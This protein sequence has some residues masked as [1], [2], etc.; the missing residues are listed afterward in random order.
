MS[1]LFFFPRVVGIQMST[2]WVPQGKERRHVHLGGRDCSGLGERAGSKVSQVACDGTDF[3][4]SVS[5][6]RPSYQCRH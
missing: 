5:W 1:A 6:P 3:H 2:D 4:T